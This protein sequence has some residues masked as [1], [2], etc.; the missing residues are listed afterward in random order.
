VTCSSGLKQQRLHVICFNAKNGSKRWER[1]FWATGRTMCQPKMCV[2]ASTPASDGERIVATFSSN[3]IFCLDL[4]GNLIWVR[5][6]GRDYPNASNSV[7][8]SS[9]L[10]IADGVVVVQVESEAE[11]F[12]A[13]LDL[14]TGINR[15]KIERPRKANWT[16]PVLLNGAGQK[17]VLLQTSTG[18]TAIEPATGKTIW[19]SLDNA[20]GIPSSTSVSGLLLVPSRGLTALQLGSREE[21]PKQLWQSN[22]M[23]PGTPSPVVVG[24]KVFVLNDA[25]V[26]TS[27]Q[28]TNG[29]RLWQLRLQGPFSASPVATGHFIYCVSEKGVAQVVDISKPEGA[30]VSEV[31]LAE[32]ILSTP[33]I[34]S[35][36]IYFRSDG[37]LWRF[38]KTA[39]AGRAE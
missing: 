4:D 6:L 7:G 15:W 27:G 20:A 24:D 8:M 35:G 30:I 25:G 38:G 22:Q 1:Q 29:E 14:I 23:R 12:T 5:G 19:S 37:H 17:I 34:S 28:S 39:S 16:S 9:S 10:V 36:A 31:Q 33:A 3:D 26:L 2:A 11:A 13:G 32:T 18:V 21:K